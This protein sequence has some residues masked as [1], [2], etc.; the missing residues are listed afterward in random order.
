MMRALAK[1]IVNKRVA[2]GI[3]LLT[4]L[5]AAVSP[6]W[7]MKLQNDDNLLA[8]LPKEN[9]AVKAFYDV[10]DRF[11]GLDVALVGIRSNDPFTGDFLGR[12]K[13][14]S[15]TLGE[16]PG[17]EYVLSLT[18]VED[19]QPD[20][21]GGI[22]VGYL[23]TDPPKDA[24]ES[25]ALR[26]KVMSRDQVVGNLIAPDGKAILIYCFLRPGTDPKPAANAVRGVVE[27]A[28]PAEEKFWGGGP[29]IQSYIYG[30]TEKDLKK[31]TP[32]ACIVI[33]VI[34]VAS[35]RDAIGSILALFS[36]GVGIVAALAIMAA[37]GVKANLVLGSMPV[38]L[39]SL[40][41]AY[42]IHLLTRYYTVADE[43]GCEGALEHALTFL[44]PVIL[45]TGF[46]TISGLLSFM[47]MDMAPMRTFGLFTAIGVFITLVLTV[48]FV[49]AVVRIVELKGK[50][51]IDKPS[52][53]L[54]TGIAETAFKKR[55]AAGA[56]LAA[57]AAAGAVY[58][59]RLDTRLDNA[60]FFS[61]TSPPAEAERFLRD[62]FGGSQFF[63]IQISGDMTDPAVLREVR[64][65]AD[66]LAVMPG[67]SSVN[68]VGLVVAKMNE[69]MDGDERIPD[70][71]ARAKALYQFLEGRKA[72]RQLVT[73]DKKHA[74]LHVKVAT[75]RAIELEMMLGAIEKIVTEKIPTRYTVEEAAGP[76]RAEVEAKLASQIEA[77]IGAIAKQLGVPLSPEQ[78]SAVKEK[79]KIRGSASP[80][81]IKVAILTFLK[82]DEFTG[83]LPTNPPDAGDKIAAA[84]ATLDARATKDTY[85]KTIAKALDKPEDDSA[86]KDLASSMNKPVAAIISR[87]TA[88]A[89]AARLVDGAKIAMPAGDKGRRLITAIGAALLELDAPSGAIADTSGKGA[90]DVKLTGLPL[91]NQGLSK[92]VARNQIESFVVAMVLVFFIALYLYRSLYS[93][94]LALAPMAITLL[95]VYGGMGV[96]GVRLDIGTSMLAS[97][98]IGA[99]VDYAV[100]L[101][102]AWKA[103]GDGKTATDAEL[104][105][106]A[107][108]SSRLVGR[109]I[110]TNAIMVA[111]GFFVLTMGEA[112]P[113]QNVGSLTA[114]AMMAAGL[115]TF[116]VIPVLARRPRYDERP[117]LGGI[118]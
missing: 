38:I 49:P 108:Y 54:I 34:A 62:A 97:L 6:V 70:T 67:V 28:F 21:K 81:A 74:L 40:G 15:R 39:F 51:S 107:L 66:T 63:Q 111:A 95:V 16:T 88:L 10:N 30:A 50:R 114:A 32:W 52:G 109:A 31:L 19:F 87:Q 85:A 110:W 14:A 1:L 98:S 115:A 58:T 42:P 55:R 25:A 117:R 68:H 102:A 71:S 11:G 99:G 36:T 13:T 29:F 20:P 91:L 92:S 44:G 80:A 90:L 105:E 4:L 75:D 65:L 27:K 89:N 106:A 46:V 112:K 100:H 82:S 47:A 78:A 53:K 35:F 79:V 18:T 96:M 84:L 60:A 24:A 116:A 7:A 48:T 56:L 76:K 22:G 101:L 72:V 43:M 93:A 3:V 2:W 118:V 17:V 61:K 86:V 77:R 94:L 9:P 23:V 73:D 41:S 12:L 37:A 104:H 83:D 45:S 113:L 26:D 69:A 8:F 5:I 33:I 64:A 103:K 57:V 59:A